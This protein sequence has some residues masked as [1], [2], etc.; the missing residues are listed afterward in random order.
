MPRAAAGETS[1]T[2]WA[3]TSAVEPGS[4]FSPSGSSI[5]TGVTSVSS[6]GTQS[7]SRSRPAGSRTTTI[8]LGP[9]DGRPAAAT[10]SAAGVPAGTT[11]GADTVVLLAC[12]RTGFLADASRAPGAAR[13]RHALP[14]V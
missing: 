13:Q 6:S 10:A 8:A 7:R 14:T 11:T 12:G 9:D 1:W 4:T 5:A 3:G 2:A